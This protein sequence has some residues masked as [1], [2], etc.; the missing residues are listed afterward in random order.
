MENICELCGK[1]LKSPLWVNFDHTLGVPI[2]PEDK[3]A[4][5]E[6]QLPPP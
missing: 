6:Y 3:P 4:H 1:K 2:A 5:Q